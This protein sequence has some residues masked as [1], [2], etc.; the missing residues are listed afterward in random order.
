MYIH[1]LKILF[2][3][4]QRG[5]GKEKERERNNVCLPFKLPL[6]GTWPAVQAHTLSGNQ[7]SDPFVRR[8][9]L[10]P[11]PHQPGHIFDI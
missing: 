6:L 10:N 5:E 4:F 2:I 3:Y 9:A 7:T 8:P 1:S 11:E